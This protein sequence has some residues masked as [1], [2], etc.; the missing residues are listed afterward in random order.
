VF[1][2]MLLL[3]PLWLVF[4]A[5]MVAA[6]TRAVLQPQDSR[7][8]Y[9]RVSGDEVRVLFALLAVFVFVFVAYLAGA[10]T[11]GIL[12]AVMGAPQI[13]LF[14]MPALLLALLWLWSRFSLAGPATLVRGTVTVLGSWELTRGRARRVFLTI[15]M[16]VAL[17]LLVMMLGMAIFMGV[18]AAIAGSTEALETAMRAD[19]SSIG[20]YFS[21]F[22]IGNIV[23][24]SFFSALGAAIILCPPAVIYRQ[25]AHGDGREAF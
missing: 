13:T 5:V 2:A 25:I 24:M 8:G 1:P 19:Y 11:L 9:L 15:L 14:L 21:P 20:G 23:A 12:G 3:A 17:H 6:A 18:A 10:L 7:L 22:M 16:A 4:G